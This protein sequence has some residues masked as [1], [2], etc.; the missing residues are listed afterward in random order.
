MHGKHNKNIFSIVFQVINAADV[1]LL[2]MHR[3]NMLFSEQ[4]KP[5]AHIMST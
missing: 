3:K 1:Y 4:L 2:L 5:C